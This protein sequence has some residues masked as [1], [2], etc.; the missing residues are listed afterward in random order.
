MTYHNGKRTLARSVMNA[1]RMDRLQCERTDDDKEAE[2][3][4]AGH[5]AFPIAKRLSGCCANQYR[6][7]FHVE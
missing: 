5:S 4:F 2:V 1:D 7:N 3:R 6:D